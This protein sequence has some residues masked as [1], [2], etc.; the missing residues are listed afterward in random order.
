[1]KY[2]KT[3]IFSLAIAILLSNVSV[4]QPYPPQ[5]GRPFKDVPDARDVTLYQVNTR[6]FSQTGDFKGVIA[7]LDSIKALGIN[8]I[9][10]MPVFPV[11]RLKGTNSPYAEKDYET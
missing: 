7:R 2:T 3:T 10:L 5:Y 9:Y 11:G 6:S 4:A 1:M 8:V